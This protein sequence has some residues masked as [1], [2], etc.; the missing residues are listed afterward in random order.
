MSYL[1]L[2]GTC[3]LM[4][5]RMLILAYQTTELQSQYVFRLRSDHIVKEDDSVSST[6]DDH[7]L[8][9]TR[10]EVL[11]QCFAIWQ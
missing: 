5:A 8:N 2:F 6:E 3:R 1:E 4:N 10:V 11:I 7:L 9:E